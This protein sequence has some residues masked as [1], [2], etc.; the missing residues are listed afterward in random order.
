MHTASIVRKNHGNAR[1]WCGQAGV[2][3]NCGECERHTGKKA[4]LRLSCKSG[5]GKGLMSY[6]HYHDDSLFGIPKN[7]TSPL[8][9][10]PKWEWKAP[11]K[12]EVKENRSYIK[13]LAEKL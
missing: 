2:Y 3:I 12:N 9:N 8:L 11:K 13:D 4:S 1:A 5:P 10:Q 6:Y 7:E